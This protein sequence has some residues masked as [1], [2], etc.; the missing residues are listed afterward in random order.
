MLSSPA[1][2]ATAVRAVCLCLS[3]AEVWIVPC[4][5][6]EE[7]GVTQRVGGEEPAGGVW[8]GINHSAIHYEGL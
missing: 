7:T 5:S 8:K 6:C 1:H 4:G 3:A 2:Q